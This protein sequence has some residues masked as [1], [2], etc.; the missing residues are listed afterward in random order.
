MTSNGKWNRNTN[1]TEGGF[2]FFVAT[3][4]GEAQ[5]ELTGQEKRA[6]AEGMIVQGFMWHARGD[7]DRF[8][9]AMFQAR[10]F[11]LNHL[12]QFKSED[13][14]NRVGLPEF[15][16]M[17]DKAFHELLNRVEHPLARQRLEQLQMELDIPPRAEPVREGEQT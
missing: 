2:N 4:F 5:T 7:K 3:S 14:R 17:R 13:H 11:Y 8:G 12:G 6:V 15:M 9:G 16:A 1:T 10:E